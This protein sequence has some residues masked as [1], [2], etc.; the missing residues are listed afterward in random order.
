NGQLD[1]ETYARIIAKKTASLF[2]AAVRL[3]AMLG[4]GSKEQVEAL[5][6]YGFNLGLAFQIVDDI[7]DLIADSQ[8]LGKTAGLDIVQG[9]GFV[10]AATTAAHNGAHGGNGHGTATA[11]I[12]IDETD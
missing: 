5:A 11:V 2:A 1:R 6:Q 10:T 4:G 8:K 9:K 3:G 7:L 12:D